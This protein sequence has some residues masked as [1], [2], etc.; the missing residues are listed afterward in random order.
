MPGRWPLGVGAGCCAVLAAL[1]DDGIVRILARNAALRAAH[2]PG[3]TDAAVRRLIQAARALGYCLNP[4][5][6]LDNRWAIGVPVYDIHRRPVASPRLAAIE[7]RLGPT[8][9]AALGKRLMQVS[10][11]LTGLRGEAGGGGR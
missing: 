7:Q 11:A 8:R 5:W 6:V 2:Y 3:C 10:R 4:G 9:R 1:S